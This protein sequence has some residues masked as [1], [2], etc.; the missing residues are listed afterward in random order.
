MTDRQASEP[1]HILLVEDNP[2]D[3]RLAREAFEEGDVASVLHVARDG[4]AGLDFLYQ[5]GEYEDAPRPALVLLDLHLPGVDGLE[6]LER[7]NEDADLKRIP[8]I[9]L[10][11]SDADD[12]VVR[13]Y[14]RHANAYLT[15]PFGPDDFA[16]LVRTFEAFWFTRVRLPPERSEAASGRD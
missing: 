9:V 2:G 13:S 5:R 4:E 6:L 3:V 12:D 14:E 16:A 7:V 11:S 15:K 10:T 8:T 1:F